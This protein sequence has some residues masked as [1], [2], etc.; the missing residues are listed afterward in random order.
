MG[1]QLILFS[2][3]KR[4]LK[5]GAFILCATRRCLDKRCGAPCRVPDCPLVF[6]GE[7]SVVSSAAGLAPQTPQGAGSGHEGRVPGQRPFHLLRRGHRP[8][9]RVARSS[10]CRVLKLPRA[11]QGKPRRGPEKSR[12]VPHCPAGKSGLSSV[13]PSMP[14][15]PSGRGAGRGGAPSAVGPP[16]RRRPA[17]SA[18]APRR[19]AAPRS[20]PA[21]GPGPSVAATP[22]AAPASSCSGSAPA[23]G[24]WLPRAVGWW[25]GENRTISAGCSARGPAEEAKGAGIAQGPPAARRPGPRVWAFLTR[26]ST[27]CPVLPRPPFPVPTPASVGRRPNAHSPWITGPAGAAARGSCYCWC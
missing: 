26:V 13:G 24:L 21:N 27:C 17:P 25:R 10:V 15:K 19:T 12:T 2:N 22:S 14:P 6:G 9:A 7:A 18:P 3:F 8:G 1:S 4:A 20:P 16:N 5:A 23:P 11:G